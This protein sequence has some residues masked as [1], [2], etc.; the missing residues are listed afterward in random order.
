MSERLSDGRLA[1]LLL[2]LGTPKTASDA[3]LGCDLVRALIVEIQ[4]RRASSP[5]A[6][7]DAVI[8]EWRPIESAPKDGSNILII[9]G[10]AYSPEARQGWWGGDAWLF[11][12]RA[13]KFA[14]GGIGPMVEVTHW[15]PLPAPPVSLKETPNGN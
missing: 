14:A 2:G 7:R 6:G 11:W 9:A 3:I 10:N 8:E 12:S 4:E 13:E 15:M 5:A 1:G